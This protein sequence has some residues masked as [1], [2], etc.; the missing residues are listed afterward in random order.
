[1]RSESTSFPLS[2]IAPSVLGTTLQS[3]T[4]L[5]IVAV[6][7]L[8]VSAKIQIPLWPVPMTMQTYV[9]LVIGM[10][11]GLRLGLVAV[12]SYLALGALGLPVF[13]G[14]PAQGVGLPYMLG[15]TGG[16]LAGFLAAVVACGYLAQR[17]WD[18]RLS[19]SLV[20]MALGHV[21][22]FAFGV[23][24]LANLVGIE[25]AVQ[26]GLA[27]FALG[28]VVKTVLAAVSLPVA[29]RCVQRRR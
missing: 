14:T 7:L 1:M 29:W 26:A 28:T 22:I 18:R 2:P 17:G 25:R 24:W 27:P 5:V 11:Y 9:V 21:L 6:A 13:A 4:W 12:G 15:P 3:R 23:A 16:Y 19:T 10:G 8:T 20:A